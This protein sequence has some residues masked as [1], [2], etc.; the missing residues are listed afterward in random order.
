[1]AVV[2]DGHH[3]P[4]WTACTSHG[5]IMFYL[6]S[7]EFESGA[8]SCAKTLKEANNWKM[9]L[10]K[11]LNYSQWV[12]YSS[13][14]LELSPPSV[15]PFRLSPRLI[16]ASSREGPQFHPPQSE[17]VGAV[18]RGPICD[19]RIGTEEGWLDDSVP[20]CEIM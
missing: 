7:A 18:E 20:S 1:M 10:N 17:V 16:L 14:A 9:T 11:S 19:S 5:S 4:H 15:S 2:V 8:E 3:K 6:H 13:P 12:H